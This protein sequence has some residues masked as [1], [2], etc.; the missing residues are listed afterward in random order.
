MTP[1]KAK[2]AG[3][4]STY[5]LLF[6]KEPAVCDV[7]GFSHSIGLKLFFSLKSK[8]MFYCI[9]SLRSIA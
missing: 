9:I 5:L 1:V 2:M 8:I 4:C 7:Q 6:T 3:H